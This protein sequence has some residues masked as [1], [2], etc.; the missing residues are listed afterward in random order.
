MEGA[1]RVNGSV[2]AD[3]RRFFL[4]EKKAD[5]GLV[6]RVNVDF[7]NVAYGSEQRGAWSEG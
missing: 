4:W 2:G 6:R 1:K 3:E 5:G 7:L